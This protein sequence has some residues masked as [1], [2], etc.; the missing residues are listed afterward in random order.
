MCGI[1]LYI[2][3]SNNKK[4]VCTHLRIIF[5]LLEKHVCYIYLI[6]NNNN[7]HFIFS[8][9]NSAFISIDILPLICLSIYGVTYNIYKIYTEYIS[10][11][12]RS[13]GFMTLIASFF[14]NKNG[15]RKFTYLVIGH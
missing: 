2:I 7:K 13:Q 6:D 10:P 15:S 11:T 14:L 12:K 8:Y 1:R 5:V 3:C 4:T 9:F